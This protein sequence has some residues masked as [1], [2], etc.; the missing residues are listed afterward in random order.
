METILTY[1]FFILVGVY[2]GNTNLRS[3][4]NEEI[5]H[6]IHSGHRTRS[7]KATTDAQQDIKERDTCSYCGKSVEELGDMKGY[8]FCQNCEKI[9]PLKT[10]GKCKYGS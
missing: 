5:A 10:R 4:I 8:A 1:L 7:K 3:K 9:Q 6:M 2:L